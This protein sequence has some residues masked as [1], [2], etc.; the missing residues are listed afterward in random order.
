MV[1]ALEAVTPQE[2]MVVVV[3]EVIYNEIPIII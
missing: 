3:S 2:D 1:V